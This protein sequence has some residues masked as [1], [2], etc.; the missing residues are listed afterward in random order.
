MHLTT[1]TY[2]FLLLALT[3]SR[4]MTGL[5]HSPCRIRKCRTT[6]LS[7]C[8]EVGI[9]SWSLRLV[10]SVR[11]DAAR[12]RIPGI[13]LRWLGSAELGG[14]SPGR[15]RRPATQSAKVGGR[16]M[17]DMVLG[18]CPCC[19]N[20][21]PRCW[22]RRLRQSTAQ[23]ARTKTLHED[24]AAAVLDMCSRLPL[25]SRTRLD[26]GDCIHNLQADPGHRWTSLHGR[27]W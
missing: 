11:G 13:A 2:L 25:S 6:K 7:T 1:P 8:S 21:F 15:V 27:Q 26:S 17:E 24:G 9:L 22:I 12:S 23:S 19:L 14:K 18:L 10:C 3:C 16:F 20:T 5:I 4:T